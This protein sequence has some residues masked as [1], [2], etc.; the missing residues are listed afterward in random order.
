[1]DDIK[2]YA[3]NEKELETFIQTI[4]IYGLDVEIEFGIEKFAML[5]MKKKKIRET[6]EGIEQPNQKN[7]RTLGEKENYNL[8]ILEADIK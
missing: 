5:T 7:I 1:M 6:T 8:R 4:R 2:I 3:K